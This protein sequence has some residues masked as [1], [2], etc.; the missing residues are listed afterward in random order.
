MDG[1]WLPVSLYDEWK[2][3]SLAVVLFGN[4]GAAGCYLAK[5]M[6]NARRRGRP[7]TDDCRSFSALTS[8]KSQWTVTSGVGWTP[9]QKPEEWL[10]YLLG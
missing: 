1:D 2:A 7:R 4:M 5:E 3:C 9:P 8:P 10:V 6:S